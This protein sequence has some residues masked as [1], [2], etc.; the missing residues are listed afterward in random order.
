MSIKPLL[1]LQIFKQ[2]SKGNNCID[3]T[4]LQLKMC[5]F[6]LGDKESKKKRGKK[7]EIYTYRQAGR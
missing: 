5:S 7:K 3:C 6:Y 4:C 2:F 1:V